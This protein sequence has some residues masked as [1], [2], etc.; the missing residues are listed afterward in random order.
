MERN[1]R[2]LELSVYDIF[3][4]C[5]G[6]KWTLHVLTQIRAGVIRPGELER[7]ADGLTTK[8]LNERLTKLTSLGIINRQSHPEVP[9]RVEYRLT[10]FGEQFVRII[11]QVHV[12]QRQFAKTDQPSVAPEP[13]EPEV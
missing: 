11:D 8:V 13:Q 2:L 4:K 10:G 3:E 1:E 9:P 7:T 5:I 6:C 12:L